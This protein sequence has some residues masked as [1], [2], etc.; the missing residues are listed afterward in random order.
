MASYVWKRRSDGVNIINI[1]KTC[2][3]GLGRL[4][5]TRP[6]TRR[7]SSPRAS[8]LPSRR[9]TTSASS[10]R[11]R[12]A[13]ARCSSSPRRPVPRPCPSRNALRSS[14][15]TTQRRPLH[16]RILHQ[17]HHPLVQG[18]ASRRRHRPAH[19]RAGHPRGVLRQHP[20]HLAL[21]HR[22]ADAVRRRRDSLQQQCGAPIPGPTL[23]HAQRASTPSD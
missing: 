7:S 23:T 13:T 19:R 4:S 12:T 3:D 17:L 22:R 14:M 11:A 8:S 9:P 15:L 5:L 21:R 10:R 18:A 16:A 2:V 6:A 20:R 1:G